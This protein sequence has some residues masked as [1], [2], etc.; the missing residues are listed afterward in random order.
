MRTEPS[1]RVRAE[2]RKIDRDWQRRLRY[3]RSLLK[4]PDQE[5]RE[6]P[7]CRRYRPESEFDGTRCVRCEQIA[8]DALPV[9]GR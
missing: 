2:L 1:E 6:C 7:S 8:L 9:L 3:V 4:V 5:A